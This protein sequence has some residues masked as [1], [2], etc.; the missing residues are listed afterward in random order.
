MRVNL[1]VRDAKTWKAPIPLQQNAALVNPNNVYFAGAACNDSEFCQILQIDCITKI[2]YV[3]T[4]QNGQVSNPVPLNPPHEEFYNSMGCWD[5]PDYSTEIYVDKH[6]NSIIAWTSKTM[7][8]GANKPHVLISFKRSNDVAWSPPVVLNEGVNNNS[9]VFPHYIFMHNSKPPLYTLI[10]SS[11]DVGVFSIRCSWDQCDAPIHMA[12]E[13]DWFSAA[14]STRGN[15]ALSLTRNLYLSNSLGV[16]EADPLDIQ[17]LVDPN[18]VGGGFEGLEY[19][20][21]DTL[22]GMVK[23]RANR[24]NRNETVATVRME[25]DDPVN[26]A[27]WLTSLVGEEIEFQMENAH[28]DLTYNLYLINTR[29]PIN[30][31]LFTDSS[32]FF[33]TYDGGDDWTNP[34]LV[35]Q[36]Q[37]GSG[38]AHIWRIELSANPNENALM[39]WGEL[40]TVGEIYASFYFPKQRNPITPKVKV[41]RDDNPSKR[42]EFA[43]LFGNGKAIVIANTFIFDDQQPVNPMLNHRVLLVEYK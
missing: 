37:S 2:L 36:L 32:L 3:T 8:A 40:A 29:D 42:L 11:E 34:L 39:A 19:H 5:D 25:E 4:Y 38:I 43:H 20:D 13:T 18:N 24:A 30:R 14:L 7:P 35:T 15:L 23:S 1:P 28:N 16:W 27:H 41:I 33:R 26:S 22:L 21:E 10:V 12:D 17:V 6:R 9:D 31:T